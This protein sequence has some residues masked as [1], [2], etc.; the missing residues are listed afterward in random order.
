MKLVIPFGLPPGDIAHALIEPFAKRFPSTTHLLNARQAELTPWPVQQHGCTACEALQLE[1]LGYQASEAAP[2][3]AGLGPLHAGI[4]DDPKPVWV[5]QFSSTVIRQEGATLVP[6]ALLEVSDAEAQSLEQAAEPYFGS[7]NDGIEIT[8]VAKGIWRVHA[9]FELDTPTISPQALLARD[10]GDWWPTTPYLR[11]WRKRVNE[12]QMAWHAHPVNLERESK[13]RP[14]INGVWLYGGGMPFEPIPQPDTVWVGQLQD[15]AL[16]SDWE[17]WL[18]N[19]AQV[20]SILLA[21][22]PQD[23]IILCNDER[24]VTL[25]NSPGRWWRHLFNKSSK[26]SW[27]QWW[28]NNQS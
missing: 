19:W 26:E 12:I 18:D 3:G 10:L 15:Y 27:R 28:L 1:S 20:E 13:G 23:A 17:Q 8:P 4:K 21:A 11:A 16:R 22:D 9:D 2:I 7:N 6:Y 5:A 25:S 14:P 24:I